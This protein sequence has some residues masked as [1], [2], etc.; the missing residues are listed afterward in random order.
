MKRWNNFGQFYLVASVIVVVIVVGMITVFNYS[1][2]L[3]K[4]NVDYFGKEFEFESEK[5]LDY[6]LLNGV[7]NIGGFTEEYS[8]Y[9][10]SGINASFIYGEET[11]LE[12]YTYISG[13]KVDLSS[14]LSVVSDEIYFSYD[15][16]VYI[17]DLEKGKNFYFVFSQEMGGEKYVYTN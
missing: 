4:S 11:S 16:D 2:N 10:G 1:G 15:G 5:V 6:D 17:F 12:A 13:S 9:L 8:D 3:K 14:D 7:S